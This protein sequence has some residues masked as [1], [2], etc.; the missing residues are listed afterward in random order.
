[1]KR[2]T[3]RLG[4]TELQVLKELAKDGQKL[5]EIVRTILIKHLHANHEPI[6]QSIY[7]QNRRHNEELLKSYYAR[8][9]AQT[10]TE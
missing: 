2:V 3:V 7:D 8:Q 4:A 6:Y 5:S 10:N 9:K 1:M